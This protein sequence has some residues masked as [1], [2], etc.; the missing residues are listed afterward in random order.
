MKWRIA[1]Y[2]EANC[3]DFYWPIAG[4]QATRKKRPRKPR[5]GPIPNPLSLSPLKVVAIRPFRS[6]NSR[7]GTWLAT[8]SCDRLRFFLRRC[9]SSLRCATAMCD[10]LLPLLFSI[11]NNDQFDNDLNPQPGGANTS[12]HIYACWI[13]LASGYR[14]SYASDQLTGVSLIGFTFHYLACKFSH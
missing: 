14:I 3:L 12:S 8:A 7:R 10:P 4:G 9:N 1:K 13:N 2:L 5:R 6:F 11:L